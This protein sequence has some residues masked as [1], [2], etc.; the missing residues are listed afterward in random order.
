MER[1]CFYDEFMGCASGVL[2]MLVIT[3][4]LQR[5]GGE[6]AEEEAW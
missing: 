1:C 5:G 3:C 6:E 4:K 2:L